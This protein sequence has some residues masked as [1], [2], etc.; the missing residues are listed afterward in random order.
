[1]VAVSAIAAAAWLSGSGPR[2]SLVF[3]MLAG[4][5]VSGLAGFAFSAVA[6]AL[7]FHWSEPAAVVPVL[8]A[9][10][11]TTQLFAVAKL[12]RSINWR[13]CAVFLAGG[14]FGIP[15]G[16]A[17]LSQLDPRL[18][19][20]LFGAFLVAYGSFLLLKP[21]VKLRARGPLADVVV[22]F[23]G[24]IAGGALAFPGVAPTI[25][26]ILQKT[27]KDAQRGIVQPFI[28]VMQ[29]ATLVYFS[30]L[31]LLGAGVAGS[32]LACAPAALFGTWL[33]LLL[34]DR[35]NDAAFRRVVLVFL[36]ISGLTLLL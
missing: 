5:V 7:A 26:C 31:G 17:A 10:S 35:I 33:G 34:F 9:C 21:D 14:V 29:L 1:L 11:V 30:R 23:F 16:A 18:F 24:G 3:S 25:W 2:P 6:G 19:A 8:L 12:R 27:P 32:Y 36:V 13:R 4:G 22:G 20:A 15:I 28:L